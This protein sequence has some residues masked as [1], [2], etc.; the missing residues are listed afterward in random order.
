MESNGFVTLEVSK[1]KNAEVAC[2]KITQVGKYHTR[3]TKSRVIEA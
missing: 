3:Y 2:R 1:M